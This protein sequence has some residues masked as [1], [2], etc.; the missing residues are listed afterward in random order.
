[1]SSFPCTC[2]GARWKIVPDL[3]IDAFTLAR[4]DATVSELQHERDTV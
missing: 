2:R 4:L 1:M 3:K